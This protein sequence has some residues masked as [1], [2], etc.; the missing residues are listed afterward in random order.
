MHWD[1]IITIPASRRTSLCCDAISIIYNKK[2]NP[3]FIRVSEDFLNSHK[4][5]YDIISDKYEMDV[6][7][8][9]G[10]SSYITW[11]IRPKTGK[12]TNTFCVDVIDTI[13]TNVEKPLTK[14]IS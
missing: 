9:R 8:S 6:V 11:T 5:L 3:K 1:N 10:Y 2:N 13:L 4:G 7:P 14:K 12:P